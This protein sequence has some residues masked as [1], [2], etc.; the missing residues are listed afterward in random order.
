MKTVRRFPH[1]VRHVEHTTIPMRDGIKLAARMWIPE[2]TEPVPALLEFIPYRKRDMT[3]RRD[4]LT[5]PYFAGHGYASVRVDLRGSGD[6]EG[7][8]T[9]EYLEE[10]QLDAIDILAWLEEQ[11]WCNGRVG[12][13]G[14]SWGGFN[15]L[16]VAA[17]RPPQLR[18]IITVC[19]TDDRYTDDVHYMG[20][21]LLGDNL[22]WAST[23][24]A[25]NSCPPDP[26]LTPDWRERWLRR[27]EGSGLWLDPW[28]RHQRRD[29]YYKH[30]SICEHYIDVQVPVLAVSGWADGYTNG[31]FRMLGRLS[32]P[33]WGLIG[34][35]GHTYPH[36][37]KPGPAIGFLQEALR[38]WNRW[39]A[40]EQN[41]YE[42]TPRL[43][44]YMQ[45]Y[46]RP[47]ATYTSRPGYWIATDATIDSDAPHL[48][49]SLSRDRLIETGRASGKDTVSRRS[50]DGAP[51][52]LRSPL[53]V[54]QFAGKWCSYASTP[55]LPGDQREEDGGSLVY[56]TDALSA[57]LE[58]LGRPVARIAFQPRAEAGTVAV[59]LSDVAPTGEA[60]RV[61][62]GVMNLTHHASHEHPE[63]LVPGRRYRVEVRL[64]GI[65]HRFPAGNRIRLS[66]STS[67]W[68]LI[69]TP[70]RWEPLTVHPRES[71][72]R[73]PIWSGDSLGTPDTA[74]GSA[75][76]SGPN[77]HPGAMFA[78]PEAAPEMPVHQRSSTESSWSMTRDLGASRSSV[79]IVKDDGTYYLPE[80]D[81]AVT[82][83]AHE[84]YDIE[85]DDPYSATGRTHRK[86]A[87]SR[88]GWNVGTETRTLLRC[89]AKNF[90]IEAEL[91][92]YESGR[93]IF[94]E[95]YHRV[96][97]RDHV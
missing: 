17:L 41:G 44:A 53:T 9:D 6:S 56:E 5:H 46:E 57:P 91:D 34:P 1:R 11:P 8:L 39:L 12:M 20:G 63:A 76:T 25:Y 37:G 32:A 24:F 14:I 19:S 96:I 92:A 26:E 13:F 35:W 68:P 51:Q 73:L 45:D 60:Y 55:D 27:L 82:N 10:E 90:I 94:S 42:S 87:F 30:G 95:N 40:G 31:V 75:Q 59:R 15:A 22:S 61:T 69:W 18:A 74:S 77:G 80:I 16:Q 49:F 52:S 43:R 65:A 79:R 93:R 81:L 48:T 33:V 66:I 70:M 78:P 3:R 58:I 36:M 50:T 29:A 2:S 47:A 89:D 62:Y 54:G 97:P 4:A 86:R 64:N 72:L 84:H 21:C 88:D 83:S 23:M 71:E 38:F 7:V 28:L 67:Y 85:P